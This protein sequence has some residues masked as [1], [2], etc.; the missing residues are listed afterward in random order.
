MPIIRIPQGNKE[1]FTLVTR[2]Q[3]TYV[4]S[5]LGVTG[6]VQVFARN[7]KILKESAPVPN[8][9]YNPFGNATEEQ[10]RLRNISKFNPKYGEGI[11][12]MTADGVAIP[13][14]ESGTTIDEDI[15]ALK[16][17]VKKIED[18]NDQPEYYTESARDFSDKLEDLLT[19][20]NKI[21]QSPR[22]SKKMEII[23][24]TPTTKYSKDSGAKSIVRKILMPHYRKF[25]PETNWAYTNYNCLN[26]FTGEGI[27]S[28]SALIYKA[29]LEETAQGVSP[30]RYVPSQ[31]FTFEFHVNPRYTI[32]NEGEDFH[33]GT[34]LHMS[35]CYA[36]SLVSGSKLDDYNKTSGYRIMLQLSHSAEISPSQIALTASNGS[37]LKSDYYDSTGP[38]QGDLIFLSSDNS[39]KRNHWHHVSITWAVSYT[40]L[41]AHET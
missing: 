5:S 18:F 35:S 41:R 37:Y 3:R 36:V 15:N 20:I 33:A 22:S 11:I 40:H 17:Q 1:V 19:K 6:S 26:F 16:A 8:F 21:R 7:S 23:R 31:S 25:D 9:T 4:S 27:P 39:L 14:D 24:F 29:G 12:G 34:I 10:L 32:D 30:H 13:F 28:D 2:P 38:D